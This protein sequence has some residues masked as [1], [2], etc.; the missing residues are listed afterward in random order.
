[1]TKVIGLIRRRVTFLFKK[2]ISAVNKLDF[3]LFP[4]PSVQLIDLLSFRYV[5]I[6]QSVFIR[7]SRDTRRGDTVKTVSFSKFRHNSVESE[8]DFVTKNSSWISK[9]IDLHSWSF[10]AQVPENSE[11]YYIPFLIWEV[12]YLR[13]ANWF[14]FWVLE[15]NKQSAVSK[16]DQCLPS[17]VWKQNILALKAFI[18]SAVITT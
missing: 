2:E 8:L 4:L 9:T 15:S 1:M 12:M 14:I 17:G 11:M 3:C 6:C 18:L 13:G 5:I 16:R 7:D 10:T